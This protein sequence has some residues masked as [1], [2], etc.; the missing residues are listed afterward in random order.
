MPAASRLYKNSYAFATVFV[1][2]NCVSTGNVFTLE[3]LNE[4]L[5]V[6]CELIGCRFGR[7]PL[8]APW[9]CANSFECCRQRVSTICAGGRLSRRH[10]GLLHD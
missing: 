1:R 7:A 4:C 2:D 9:P 8:Y 5:G 6:V 3:T 10:R